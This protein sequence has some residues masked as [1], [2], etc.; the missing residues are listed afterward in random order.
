MQTVSVIGTGILGAATAYHLAK[1]G[2]DVTMIDREEQGQATDAAAGIVCP[3]ISQRRNQA[4]YQLAKAGARYYPTL[5]QALEEEGEMDTGYAKVGAI[6]LHTEEK[7]Q[8]KMVERA[9]KRREDAP[10]IGEVIPIS[11]EDTRALFPPLAPGYRSVYVSGAARVNGRSLRRALLASAMRYGAKEVK[12]D[13]TFA[14]EGADLVVRVNGESL[15]FDRV[16]VT[17]GAWAKALLTPLG[18]EFKVSPQKAQIVHLALPGAETGQWP[19][20][21]APANHYMLAFGGG[22]V[23]TGATHEDEKGFD[24]RRTL[25]GMNEIFDKTLKTAPGL[26]ESTVLET[27]V[28][29]RP[30][31][32]GFLPVIGRLPGHDHIFVANG[33]GASGLTVGPFLG[34]ELA[35]LVRGEKTEL[36]L[37]PY[38]VAGAID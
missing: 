11:E 17:A 16:I 15:R 23:V 30:Y 3:W 14:Y 9:L 33:L 13:A 31:T 25:A 1:A 4:W 22:H 21:M 19:V 6:S 10:E 24:Q 27:R 8:L 2:V 5:I 37:A 28:G 18:V 34:A 35:R 20:V 36:D 26:A 12:G 29:F 32:P 38:D 7:K